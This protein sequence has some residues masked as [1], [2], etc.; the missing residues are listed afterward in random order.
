MII[1]LVY[2]SVMSNSLVIRNKKLIIFICDLGVFKLIHD[3]LVD[4]IKK[5][6]LEKP[7]G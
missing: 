2:I 5:I 1:D 4:Y 3:Y 7:C 6:L